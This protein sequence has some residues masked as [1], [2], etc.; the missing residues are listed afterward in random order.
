[1]VTGSMPYL[2]K[3]CQKDPLYKFIYHKKQ[4]LFWKEWSQ[5]NYKSTH[6]KK[7]SKEPEGWKAWAWRKLRCRSPD[8]VKAKKDKSKDVQYSDEFKDLVF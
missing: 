1:M 7:E 6:P 3:A 8:Q 4:D 5:L 2:K